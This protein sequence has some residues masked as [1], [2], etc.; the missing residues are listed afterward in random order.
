MLR[1]RSSTRALAAFAVVLCCGCRLDTGRGTDLLARLDEAAVRTDAADLDFLGP[2]WSWHQ[3]GWLAPGEGGTEAVYW[4]RKRDASVDVDFFST[5][6]KD[7]ALVVRCHPR[8][9]PGLPVAVSLNGAPVGGFTAVPESARVDLVLPE[10]SQRP[11]RNE[12]TFTVPR[13][14]EPR[15]GEAERRPLAI[16]IRRLSIRPRG[17]PEAAVP[18]VA[19]GG[20]LRIPPSASVGFPCRGAEASALR[21]TVSEGAGQPARVD[22]ELAADDRRASLARLDVPGRGRQHRQVRIPP[23]FGPFVEIRLANAGPGTVRVRELTLEAPEQSE[24]RARKGR[25]ALPGRPNVVVFLVDT[26]RADDLGAYGAVA[27]TSPAFDGFA[28]HG[29]LFKNAVAQSAWTRP[30]VASLFTGLHPGTHGVQESTATL[31]AEVTTLA[32]SLR[33]RGYLTLGLVANGVVSPDRGFAQGFSAWN[34]GAG[35]GLHGASSDV[36]VRKAL[37]AVDGAREPYFLYVHT[38]DPHDPYE[39]SDADWEAFRDGGYRGQSD[40][41]RLI[42]KGR[43]D[44]PELAFLRSKYRGEIRHND[45][46]FGA[47]VDGLASRGLD[48]TIV[49]FTSDHGEEFLDHGGLLHRQTLYDEILHVPFAVHLP[50]GQGAGRVIDAPFR[51]VDLFPTLANLVGADVPREVEGA[52]RS[53]DWIA[54]GP[55]AAEPEPMAELVDAGLKKYAVRSGDLELIVNA[56]ARGYWR[57]DREVELYDTREDPGERRNLVDERPIAARYLR[58]QLGRLRAQQEAHRRA[59]AHR[60][61]SSEEREHLRALGYLQ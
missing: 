52:D 24:R 37:E 50:G 40:P 56:D 32:E 22:V 19:R 36:L 38:L 6:T 48:R 58:N 20:E 1:A 13:R 53:S 43:L 35:A 34:A 54:G 59:G 27:P 11:G 60:E 9:A 23:G 46:A 47:L 33:A 2:R 21:L 28:R 61:L 45:R 7:L 17:R 55:A 14:Y 15:E 8:L 12:L 41:R 29:L 49:V 26:L 10:H 44:E 3:N 57:A 18:R 31:A 25:A 4:M 42:E 16:A 5:A 39:P 30:T 51:Q